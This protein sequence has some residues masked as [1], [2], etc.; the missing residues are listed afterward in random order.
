[1]WNKQFLTFVGMERK[2]FND[3]DITLDCEN[4]LQ[5][6]R[7]LDFG[8]LLWYCGLKVLLGGMRSLFLPYGCLR[9]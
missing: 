7:D 6:G 2:I 8:V 4:T 3:W 5:L 9:T 1:M